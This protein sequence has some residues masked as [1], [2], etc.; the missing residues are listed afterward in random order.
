MSAPDSFPIK[1][2]PIFDDVAKFI[3]WSWLCHM[4]HLFW[5]FTL[6]LLFDDTCGPLWNYNIDVAWNINSRIL[7]DRLVVN[8]LLMIWQID[9]SRSSMKM[10]LKS[11][12]SYTSPHRSSFAANSTAFCDGVLFGHWVNTM[13]SFSVFAMFS[14]LA[15]VRNKKLTT[16]EYVVNFMVFPLDGTLAWDIFWRP[17]SY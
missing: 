3:A 12:S 5:E 2:D 14:S 13:I 15:H 10:F 4:V 16:S 11:C 6:T 1:V 9:L 7:A 17:A 8:G